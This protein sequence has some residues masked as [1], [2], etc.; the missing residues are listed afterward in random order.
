M[1]KKNLSLFDIINK[2]FMI[3]MMFVMLFPFWYS[4]A[5]SLNEGSDYISCLL[6]TSRC[7]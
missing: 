2:I 4:V 1:L 5:G 3:L 6:Y 7:V